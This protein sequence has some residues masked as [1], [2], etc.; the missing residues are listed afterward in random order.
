MPDLDAAY[1]ASMLHQATR[2]IGATVK[3]APEYLKGDQFNSE[4]LSD[5]ISG[6]TVRRQGSD[7]PAS[8]EA[9][10]LDDFPV[11]LGVLTGEPDAGSVSKQIRRYRN[12]ATIARSWLGAAA[13]NLHLF[14]AGPVGAI[15]V[16]EWR[17]LAA[18]IEADD[19]VC[20]KLVWLFSD[21][22]TEDSAKDFLERTFVARPWPTDQRSERLD[23]VANFS[24]P[25]GWEDA[26]QDRELDFTTL[27][28]RLI[29]LQ[30]KEAI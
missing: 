25:D 20:R 11:L 13:P 17:Q 7:L 18:E 6:S 21:F 16:P 3:D 19:R 8:V 30:K 1:L 15:G 4:V 27:V 22:P 2:A 26:L 9:L 5:A 24:L 23:S 28:D 29:E 12:Q 14:V 10:I